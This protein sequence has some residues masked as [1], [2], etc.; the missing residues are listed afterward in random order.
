MGVLRRLS[1]AE[2]TG[3]RLSRQCVCKV[4]SV[5]ACAHAFL[6]VFIASCTRLYW[7]IIIHHKYFFIKKSLQKASELNAYDFR[8]I[9][10]STKPYCCVQ[11]G[12]ISW[13]QT[14][15]LP[16][17]MCVFLHMKNTAGDSPPRHV[18][19]HTDIS[20]ASR[21]K[22]AQHTEH[23]E[24]QRSSEHVRAVNVLS[25]TVGCK[26][27][28]NM[29]VDTDLGLPSTSVVVDSQKFKSRSSPHYLSPSLSHQSW[30]WT[31]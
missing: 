8:V 22:V 5:C 23:P 31:I 12:H 24:I 15:C 19:N 11:S 6:V 10:N 4:N 20:G 27:N 2:E 14:R 3:H 21:W 28:A 26:V 25:G 30:I 16:L 9:H 7:H 18:H 17:Q 29:Q 13:S 1:Q